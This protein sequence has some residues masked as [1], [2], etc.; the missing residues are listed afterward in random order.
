MRS[1]PLPTVVN[2]QCESGPQDHKR[3]EVILRAG[4]V[5]VA[6][7]V[8]TVNSRNSESMKIEDTGHSNASSSRG[9]Q[10]GVTKFQADTESIAEDCYDV[11]ES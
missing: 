5:G 4:V 3:L 9:L 6:K 7:S 8:D 1:L 11:P 10:R 2:V